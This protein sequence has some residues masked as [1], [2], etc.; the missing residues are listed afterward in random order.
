MSAIQQMLT[1]HIDIWTAAET[2]KRSGRGRASSSAA[3][4]YGV[5]K[6]RGLILELAIRGKLVPQDA[7]DEPASELLMRIRER[8]R[9]CLR[10]ERSK[11]AGP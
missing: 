2:E 9:K 6:L 3:R 11:T 1:D 4:V 10:M 5:R 8:K 7:S